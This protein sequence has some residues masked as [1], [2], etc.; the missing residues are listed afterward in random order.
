MNPSPEPPKVSGPKECCGAYGRLHS[1]FCTAQ[2]PDELREQVKFYYDIW[3][4]NQ[5]SLMHD[6]KRAFHEVNSL[7]GKLAILKHENNQL[8]RKWVK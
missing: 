6:R 7:R 2:T 3:L 8:R 4:D 1:T 5:K